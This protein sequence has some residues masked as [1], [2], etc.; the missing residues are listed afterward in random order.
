M[1]VELTEIE[2]PTP[3]GHHLAGLLLKTKNIE[4]HQF[5]VFG[6]ATAVK[7][8]FY[9]QLAR[10]FAEHGYSVLLFDYYGIGKS[11]DKP[12]RKIKITMAEWGSNDL[13]SVVNYVQNNFE[14][15][16]FHYV[17]HSVGGQVLG[18]LD[19]PN[20][21]SKIIF[22]S[23]QIGYWRY[24][25]KHNRSY[26]LLYYFIFPLLI[27][28]FGYLPSKRLSLGM[29]LPP[30]QARQWSRWLLQKNYLF[31][32]PTIDTTSFQEVTSQILSYSFTD[33][34]WAPL[35]ACQAMVNHYTNAEII[36]RDINPN[37]YGLKKIGH[38]GIF[39]EKNKEKFWGDFIEFLQ[40]T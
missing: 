39:R 28:I 36:Y 34:N 3:M 2:I 33:D 27:K 16:E 11:I 24:Y 35:K 10:Y 17:G 29:N 1:D 20:V 26:F 14:I 40:K 7:Y 32:D 12:L 21:F 30:N 5:I 31:D 18:M 19:N 6:S 9:I 8:T 25:K 38:F 37:D 13:Q 23:A 4:K 15:E 22:F